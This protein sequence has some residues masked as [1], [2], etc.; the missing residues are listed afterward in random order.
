MNPRP[1]VRTKDV[2]RFGRSFIVGQ[3]PRNGTPRKPYSGIWSP[4]APG[5]VGEQALVS[6][7]VTGRSRRRNRDSGSNYLR[8]ESVVV[9]V[10]N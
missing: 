6:Y 10:G 9:S 4:P 8:S 2:Y 7:R 5:R 1:S 3:A